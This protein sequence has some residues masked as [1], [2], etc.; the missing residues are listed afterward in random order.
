MPLIRL[1]FNIY[2]VYHDRGFHF[3]IRR[4]GVYQNRSIYYNKYSTCIC[5]IKK[6]LIF[7][8]AKVYEH[9]LINHDAFYYSG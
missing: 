6:S 9:Y 8:I 5:L 4:M 1:F 3:H 7:D 2:I